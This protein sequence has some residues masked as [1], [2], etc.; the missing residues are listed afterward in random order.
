MPDR[1]VQV[2]VAAEPSADYLNQLIA[3]SK[4]RFSP[5]PSRTTSPATRSGSFSERAHQFVAWR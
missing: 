1:R 2:V 3:L 5:E 4:L